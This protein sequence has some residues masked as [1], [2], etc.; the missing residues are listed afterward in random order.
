[1]SF[2]LGENGR[3]VCAEQLFSYILPGFTIDAR[4]QGEEEKEEEEVENLGG[5]NLE[6]EKEK[7]DVEFLEE[8]IL[9]S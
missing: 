7:Q 6:E 2:F 5:D 9:S 1:M 3:T 8:T 4:W